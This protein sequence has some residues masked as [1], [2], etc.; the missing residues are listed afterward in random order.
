MLSP[1]IK[2]REHDRFDEAVVDGRAVV[3]IKIVEDTTGGGVNS[4]TTPVVGLI[5][6]PVAD[7]EVAFAL[8][9]NCKGFV[10]RSRKLARLKLA[11]LTGMTNYITI[12][13]GGF[14]SESNFY[15]TQTIFIS[16]SIG[17]NEIEIVTYT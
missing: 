3:R 2:D 1:I 16:S 5:N 14:W 12:P 11:Y 6:V 8:P 13:V 10:L 4:N 9:S 7:T 15:L 17:L